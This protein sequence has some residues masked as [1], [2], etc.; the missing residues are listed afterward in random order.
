MTNNGDFV[1]NRQNRSA[2]NGCRIAGTHYSFRVTL[3]SDPIP[4]AGFHKESGK[5]LNFSPRRL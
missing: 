5:K 4:R 1:Q 3:I 2:S